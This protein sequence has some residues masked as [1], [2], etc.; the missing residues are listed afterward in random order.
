MHLI[1]YYIMCCIISYYIMNTKWSLRHVR[2]RCIISYYCKIRAPY[3]ASSLY[4]NYYIIL[5]Y[6]IIF[7]TTW[8]NRAASF[9]AYYI[10]LN[11]YVLLIILLLAQKGFGGIAL[12]LFLLVLCCITSLNRIALHRVYGSR[13][14]RYHTKSSSYVIISKIIGDYT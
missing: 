12:R 10:I 14:Q 6:Y 7:I 3:R 1:I 8:N 2:S 4:H 11:H 13:L 9:R 5:Y